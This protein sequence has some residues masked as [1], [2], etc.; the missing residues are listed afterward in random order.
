MI[1]PNDHDRFVLRQRIKLVINQ[2]EFSVPGEDGDD[3][4]AFCFVEQ[5]RFKFKEDIRFFTGPDKS[6]ELMRI[7]ARQRF[8]PKARYDITA[9]DGS[10]IGQIQ[11]VF[12]KSLLRSTFTLFD[13]TGTEVAMAQE[14][15]LPV[16]LFRRLVGL[17][18]YVGD[19]ADWL[20]I[21]YDFVFLREEQPLGIIR[22]R[23]FKLRDIYDID[24]TDDAERTLDRRMVLAA[25]VG[26]DALMAR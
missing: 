25:A 15:S 11:K 5:A 17:V 24:L 21:A 19:L 16:A 23:R 4:E 20:P 2:Y 6:Q 1:S 13:A 3:G 14:R 18:P 10:E 9:A 12:G 8:D 22:R 26:M 7:L